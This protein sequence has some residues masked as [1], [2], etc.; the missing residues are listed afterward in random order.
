MGVV[1]TCAGNR[2][3]IDFGR[4]KDQSGSPSLDDLQTEG[5]FSAHWPITLSVGRG[6]T[7]CSMTACS[8]T[9]CSDQRGAGKR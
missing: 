4:C 3:G 2:C 7:A 6:M 5:V 9:A 8:I 1:R